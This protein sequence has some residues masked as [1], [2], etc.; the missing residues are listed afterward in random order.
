MNIARFLAFAIT[1]AGY[2]LAGC[3][4]TRLLTHRPFS[5]FVLGVIGAVCGIVA[6][7]IFLIERG[8]RRPLND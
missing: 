6:I 1:N 2:F 8:S 4:I 7:S 3:A 5:A